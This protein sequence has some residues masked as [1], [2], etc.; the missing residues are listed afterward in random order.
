[1]YRVDAA[2]ARVQ[3]GSMSRC[4]LVAMYMKSFRNI[5][6]YDLLELRE[7][8]TFF[9]RFV[10]FCTHVLQDLVE[11]IYPEE[12]SINLVSMQN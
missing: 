2:L 7:H 3:G 4:E 9:G 6:N 1:M 11:A 10:N 8:E 12:N 5:L